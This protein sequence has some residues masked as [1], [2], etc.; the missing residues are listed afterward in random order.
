[1]I[2]T[3]IAGMVWY[4]LED[5]ADALAVMEDRNKLPSTYSL[6]RMRAEQAEKEQHRLGRS[7]TRVYIKPAEFVTW[8]RERGLNIDAKARNEFA[9]LGALQ[10]STDL[11]K[12]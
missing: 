10:A 1:M 11:D 4:R 8:C 6:W 2:S 12:H 5:Y 3:A 7:T 9:V